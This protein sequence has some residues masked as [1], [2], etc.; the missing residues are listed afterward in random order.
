M[1]KS[2]NLQTI[3]ILPSTALFTTPF[4]QPVA[5]YTSNAPA[6][7]P[8]PPP[9]FTP[10]LLLQCEHV[11]LAICAPVILLRLLLQAL[12]PH[13]YYVRQQLQTSKADRQSVLQG[14]AEVQ[15]NKLRVQGEQSPMQVFADAN[16][17]HS[18]I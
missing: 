11:P 4:V 8:Y 2:R 1:S 9:W 5:L 10:A 7:S 15:A 13:I 17:A 18:N 12:R 14:F 6:P 3:P 16:A